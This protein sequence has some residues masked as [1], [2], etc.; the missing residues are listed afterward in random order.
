[1]LQTCHGITSDQLVL[2][3]ES[4]HR[5]VQEVVSRDIDLCSIIKKRTLSALAQHTFNEDE[6]RILQVLASKSEVGEILYQKFVEEQMISVADILVAFPS[7]NPPIE[8]L[9]GIIPAIAPSC[10]I[11]CCQ[12]VSRIFKQ[13]K[14]RRCNSIHGSSVIT[15]LSFVK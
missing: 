7:C 3:N 6:A 2:L 15:F 14:T 10:S 5:T 8:A 1:M 13:E 12:Y 4:E 9:V 11:E